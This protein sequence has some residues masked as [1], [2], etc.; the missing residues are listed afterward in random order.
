MLLQTA[1]RVMSPTVRL[2]TASTATAH[3]LVMLAATVL[4]TQPG[5]KSTPMKEATQRA[6]RE[7]TVEKHRLAVLVALA[8]ALVPRR[9][10]TSP[11]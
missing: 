2:P 3:T 5:H 7:Q 11:C 9:L 6:R 1:A 8:Q 4:K 10:S